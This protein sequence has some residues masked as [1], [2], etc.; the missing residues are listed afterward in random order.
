MTVLEMFTN[1][2]LGL[3]DFYFTGD[4]YIYRFEHDA[5]LR[6]IQALAERFKKPVQTGGQACSWSTVITQKTRDLAEFIENPRAELDFTQ[7]EPVLE[8]EAA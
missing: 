8:R 1:N 7:P 4:N 6:F 2:Q 5:K 3:R